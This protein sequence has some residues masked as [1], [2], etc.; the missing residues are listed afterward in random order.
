[1]GGV[2][3]GRTAIKV[4]TALAMIASFLVPL[5]ALGPPA[6]A[7]GPITLQV[8]KNTYD[9]SIPPDPNSNEAFESS[10]AFA[11][12]VLD[13]AGTAVA[14]A[15]LDTDP[16]DLTRDSTFTSSL[17]PGTYTIVEQQ[18]GPLWSLALA[19]CFVASGSFPYLEAIPSTPVVLPDGAVGLEVALDQYTVCAFQNQLPAPPPPPP[20][21]VFFVGK[22]TV[23]ANT[24]PVAST[25]PFTLRVDEADGD[26]QTALVVDTD[27]GTLSPEFFGSVTVDSALTITEDHVPG[28]QLVDVLC[29]G[30]TGPPATAPPD[31]YDLL[32]DVSGQLVGVSVPN[33]LDPDIGGCQLINGPVT[34][35]TVTNSSGDNITIS[36]PTAGT[37]ISS[38]TAIDPPTMPPIPPG[39]DFP[40][41]LVDFTI[42]GVAPGATI[43]VVIDLPSAPAAGWSFWK[44]QGGAY[45]DASSIASLSG[46]MLTLSLQDNGPFDADPA[47]GVIHDPGGCR[48]AGCGCDA[49]GHSD[50]DTGGRCHLPGRHRGDG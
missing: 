28:W 4:A 29:F 16:T 39:V 19:E 31:T 14:S 13:N 10:E 30:S 27:P 38:A 11:F 15:D 50:H 44:L 35:K 40:F 45:T 48:R 5:V 25:Q 26:P 3:S 7:M 1:M 49:A 9:P 22:G 17:V 37:T 18:P 20:S 21:T 24:V 41:G 34:T 47:P 8:Q 23:D 6:G 2:S 46:S 33:P 43:D 42:S 36:S 12:R 32:T